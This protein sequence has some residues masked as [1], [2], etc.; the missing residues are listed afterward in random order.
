VRIEKKNTRMEEKNNESGIKT[1]LAES[2]E[3]KIKSNK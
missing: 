2:I 1:E 3:A